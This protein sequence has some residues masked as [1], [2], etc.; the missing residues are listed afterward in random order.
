MSMYLKSLEIAGFKSFA[1]KTKFEFSSPVT[2]VVGPNGS[3]KSNVVEAFRWVLGDQSA[4]GM[5]AKKGE[6]FIFHGS[7]TAQR[8]QHASVAVTLNNVSRFLNIDFDEVTISR[9]VYRDGVN[10]YYLNNS[11]VRLKDIVEL[12]AGAGLGT[13]Q[14]HII[15][16]GEADRLLYASS[17]ERREMIDDAL[18]LSLIEYKKDESERKLA[19]TEENLKQVEL[20]R[21]ELAPHLKYLE[22]QVEQIRKT[23]AVR[24][25]LEAL[26]R[27]Y[28]THTFGR[29][30]EERQA[31]VIELERYKLER[32]KLD[33]TRRERA[34][35]GKHAENRATQELD[36]NIRESEAEI[37]KITYE[38]LELSREVGKMEGALGEKQRTLTT[39]ASP[40]NSTSESFVK[41]SETHL[42]SLVH[43]A[44][45]LV[46]ELESLADINFLKAKVR[47]LIKDIQGLYHRGD[48]AN[49]GDENETRRQEL[50]NEISA[51]T[52][53]LEMQRHEIA[54]R[55]TKEKVM[56]EQTARLRV[57]RDLL[58]QESIE[59]EKRSHEEEITLERLTARIDSLTLL[60]AQVDEREKNLKQALS[61]I[62]YV[63]Q[64]NLLSPSLTLPEGEGGIT[65]KSKDELETL[66]RKIERMRARIEEFGGVNTDV[67]KEY[68]ATKE[69]DTFLMTEVADLEKSRLA[70]EQVKT[71]LEK[72]LETQF[73]SGIEKINAEF[74]KY[75]EL[76]FGGGTASLKVAEKIKRVKVADELTQELAPVIPDKPE[77]GLEIDVSLPRKKIRSLDL[78][79]GGERTLV[80]I[81]LLFAV[82]QVNPPPFLVLDETDAALDESNSKK[83]G[84]MLEALSSQTQLIII[85]HNRETMAHAGILYGITLGNDAISRVLSVKL[86]DYDTIKA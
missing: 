45:A 42:S 53:D 81:A 83:Y 2:A 32:D 36:K 49:A 60:V 63:I 50:G 29:L 31:H 59:A 4:K 7:Q 77:L 15:S 79:S 52:F 17:T 71:E 54:E 1:K 58:A 76:L 22:K 64:K 24:I 46:H 37:S 25:E 43:R 48:D 85:T 66:W 14:H 86:D 70:L 68:D 18:G 16:Q 21:K 51:L 35:Q 78:L 26:A 34:Q 84:D 13:S 5:R 75:F 19:K 65:L 38:R 30:D 9:H 39:L 3:G 82:T 20:L 47:E 44:S 72:K 55:E 73:E 67:L 74:A 8:L 56:R 33:V 6:D 12:L 62:S 57:S 27:D 69:R 23:E 28:F 10:E 40:A 41:I 61:D 11:K 80:S